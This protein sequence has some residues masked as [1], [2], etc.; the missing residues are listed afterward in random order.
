MYMVQVIQ[1]MDISVDSVHE[2]RPGQQENL[3]S[4]VLLYY[5][6]KVHHLPPATS[7]IYLQSAIHFLYYKKNTNIFNTDA[8]AI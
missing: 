1:I 7:S 6:N 5:L 8:I 4:D 2:L 3:V